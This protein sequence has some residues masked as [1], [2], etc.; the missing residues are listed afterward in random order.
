MHKPPVGGWLIYKVI[1]RSS[2][3]CPAHACILETSATLRDHNSNPDLK[4]CGVMYSCLSDPGV[5]NIQR[6]KKRGR[7]HEWKEKGEG[8]GKGKKEMHVA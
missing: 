7:E 6:P 3:F 5:Y 2:L 4:E 8:V 1:N